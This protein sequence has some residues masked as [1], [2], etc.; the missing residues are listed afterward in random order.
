MFSKEFLL[1]NTFVL[2]TIFGTVKIALW[3]ENHL[4]K[5]NYEYIIKN[6]AYSYQDFVKIERLQNKSFFGFKHYFATI[7]VKL[8]GNRKEILK[9]ISPTLFYKFKEGNQVESTIVKDRFGNFQIFLIQQLHEE[10][11]LKKDRNKNID[12]VCNFFLVISGIFFIFYKLK[13]K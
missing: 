13:K 3:F 9:K 10:I 8:E 4:V 11:S 12:F 1:L 6:L 2:L 7:S 5:K